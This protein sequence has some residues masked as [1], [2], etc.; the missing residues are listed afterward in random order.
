MGAVVG[1]QEG[2]S[3]GKARGCGRGGAGEEGAP[4]GDAELGGPKEVSQCLPR[5]HPAPSVAQGPCPLQQLIS[6]VCQGVRDLTVLESCFLPYAPA[7]LMMEEVHRV[8]RHRQP[9]PQPLTWNR[10]PLGLPGDGGGPCQPRVRT[11]VCFLCLQE[12]L[13]ASAGT[14]CCL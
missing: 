4:R 7:V 12:C 5:C 10:P 6:W 8:Q 1:E 9:H 13:W 11:W 14:I 3:G 2:S